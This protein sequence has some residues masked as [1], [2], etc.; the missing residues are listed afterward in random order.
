MPFYYIWI[1]SHIG[2]KSLQAN[3][4]RT[5]GAS[6]AEH[7]C[8]KDNSK[9]ISLKAK[10]QLKYELLK[11]KVPR[12]GIEPATR[13]FSVLCSTNW[14]IWAYVREFYEKLPVFYGDPE[15]ARTVDLQRDRL[16]F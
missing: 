3:S 15:R 7:F 9:E 4:S 1:I 14:A 11:I 12:A 8:F 6:F 2:T 10:K 16:A 5:N 13:G